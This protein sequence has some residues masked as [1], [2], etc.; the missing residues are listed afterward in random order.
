MCN[1]CMKHP[2][3]TFFIILAMIEAIQAIIKYLTGWHKTDKEVELEMLK[4]KEENEQ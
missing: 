2:W 4:E 3:M 1:W